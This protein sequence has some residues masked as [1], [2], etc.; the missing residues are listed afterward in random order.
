MQILQLYTLNGYQKLFGTSTCVT[1]S[2]AFVIFTS[3]SDCRLWL[4]TKCFLHWAEQQEL[5]QVNKEE[6]TLPRCPSLLWL[7]G[8]LGEKNEHRH[9]YLTEWD[10]MMHLA[11][12]NLQLSLLPGMMNQGDTVG[13]RKGLVFIVIQ[14]GDMLPSGTPNLVSGIVAPSTASLPSGTAFSGSFGAAQTTNK[15][16]AISIYFEK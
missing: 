12:S 10:N 4:L 6:K 3:E 8:I 7:S 5:K 14:N 1:L 2:V 16:R 13:N 9:S 11:A 15:Y